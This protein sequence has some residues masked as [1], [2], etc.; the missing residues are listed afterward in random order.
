MG[1]A[2]QL[3]SDEL[4]QQV[5]ERTREVHLLHRIS[6]SISSTLEQSVVLKHIVE[7]VVEVTGGFLCGPFAAAVPCV[8]ADYAPICESR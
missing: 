4:K 8:E 6:E 7:V 1:R 5:R 3:T 2:R